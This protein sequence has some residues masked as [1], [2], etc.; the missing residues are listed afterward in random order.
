M[1]VNILYTDNIYTFIIGCMTRNL[2]LNLKSEFYIC[3]AHLTMIVYT[4]LVCIRF[5]LNVIINE[6]VTVN[7]QFKETFRG[8]T[9]TVKNI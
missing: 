1:K 7:F 9:Y 3:V 4:I 6:A 2:N 8:A 5:T